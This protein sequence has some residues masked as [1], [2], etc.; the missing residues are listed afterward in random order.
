[1]SITRIKKAVCENRLFDI[2]NSRVTGDSIQGHRAREK[3][4]YTRLLT[5]VWALF[6]EKEKVN[7]ALL[8]VKYVGFP[9]VSL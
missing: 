6:V 9:K 1:M 3:V 5:F 7:L 2:S 4:V 8:S